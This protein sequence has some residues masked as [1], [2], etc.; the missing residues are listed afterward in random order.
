MQPSPGGDWQAPRVNEPQRKKQR[1]VQ[2]S[3]KQESLQA[4]FPWIS[5]IALDTKGDY[6]ATCQ[7]CIWTELQLEHHGLQKHSKTKRHVDAV[8]RADARDHEDED[9]DVDADIE[10]QWLIVVQESIACGVNPDQLH[11]LLSPAVLR[12]L[13][14][15]LEPVTEYRLRLLLD[16]MI[17]HNGPLEKVAANKLTINNPEFLENE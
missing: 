6:R 3:A 17:H 15:I 2:G 14:R 9:E 10:S 4:S 12:A 1:S 7:Y 5:S 11:R 8:H 13:K 16:T